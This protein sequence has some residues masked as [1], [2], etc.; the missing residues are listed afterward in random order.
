M[1]VG[2]GD[3]NGAPPY[4]VPFDAKP[5][6]S[7]PVPADVDVLDNDVP[8]I[9][10]PELDRLYG[11][12]YSSLAYFRHCDSLDGVSTYVARRDGI[13]VAVFLFRNE[14]SRIR[15]VNEGMRMDADEVAR[16][17]S[18]MFTR[19]P[20]AD[21]VEFHAVQT[22]ASR[23]PM[24]HLQSFCAE[25]F[26]V[27]LPATPEAYLAR[28]GAA[29]R[30]NLKRH[31]RRLERDFPS[32]KHVIFERA[33]APETLIRHVIELSR[34]RIAAKGKSFAIDEDE[35][36]RIVTLVHE[37]GAVLAV[38]VDGRLCA[39]TIMYRFGKSCISRVNAHD[40]AFDAYRPG[41]LC[42]FLAAC[43]A[44][45]NGAQQFHLGHTWY[46]YKTAL[47]GKFEAFHHLAV[48]RSPGAPARH[49][50]PAFQSAC[51]GCTLTANRWILHH[52]AHDSRLPWRLANKAL[53]AWR[54]V[55]GGRA[56]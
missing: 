43:H 46:D 3:S 23:I 14:G 44:I 50:G 54:A 21:V 31:R 41:M 45:E 2:R 24:L 42:C 13:P 22:K 10:G 16:F 26:I 12:L 29:T 19:S 37:A 55:K 52:A 8:S 25:D 20:L 27:A 7:T 4:V 32:F 48:Y 18:T 53:A 39:G 17:A 47:L 9:A 35:V 30:K 40:P 51:K 38:T 1:R 49:A 56:E 36:R 5:F 28:L 6:P 33:D 15:V 11:T 34:R